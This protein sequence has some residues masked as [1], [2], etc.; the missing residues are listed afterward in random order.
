MSEKSVW[1][2]IE[3]STGMFSSEYMASLRTADGSQVSF[4]VDKS[5]VQ[6][7]PHGNKL[8]V[9]LVSTSAERNTVL[10][11]TEAFETSSRWVELK[12]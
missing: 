6:E 3:T 4:F 11:P 9:T 2:P 10:L 8:E 1:I 12:K 5:K 7:S